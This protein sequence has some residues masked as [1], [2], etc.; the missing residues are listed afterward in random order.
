MRRQ[1]VATKADRPQQIEVDPAAAQEGEPHPL[2]DDHRDR[3]G[4]REHGEGVDADGGQREPRAM[5]L[6]A[7][8]R[9]RAGVRADPRRAAGGSAPASARRR[10]RSPSGTTTGR[11]P[12]SRCACRPA[13]DGAS[14]RAGDR[15][16]SAISTTPA[17]MRTARRST[18]APRHTTA[19]ADQA[20]ASAWP[21][22]D[23]DQRLEDHGAAPPVQAE[24]DGEQPAHGGVD[25]V[26]GAEPHQAQPR[27]VIDRRSAAPGA[28]LGDGQRGRRSAPARITDSSTSPTRRRRPAGAPGA[29]GS[30]P[31]TRGR[32][33]LSSSMPPSRLRVDLDHPALDAVRIELVVDHAVERVREVDALAVAAHLDHLRPAVERPRGPTG[34][35]RARRCRRAAACR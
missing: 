16:P 8:G 6:A 34:A 35:A 28:R 7:G 26:K 29:A 3:P 9:S 27:P 1:P 19:N 24:G 4:H 23:R 10:A 14:R 32:T 33:C 17:A 11:G 13:R 31:T 21:S 5:P 30:R 2:V 25:A 12:P 15:R 20:T 22:G 18:T